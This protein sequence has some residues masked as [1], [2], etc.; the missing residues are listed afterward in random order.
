MCIQHICSLQNGCIDV[1]GWNEQRRGEVGEEAAV[2]ALQLS[3]TPKS[4][5]IPEP[6]PPLSLILR[7]N[8]LALSRL[9]CLAWTSSRFH[10]NIW[11]SKVMMPKKSS[12]ARSFRMRTNAS[13]VWT[14]GG[15]VGYLIQEKPWIDAN[16]WKTAR[17]AA[18]NERPTCWIFLPCM[19]PLWSMMKTTFLGMRGRLDGAK[20][21][22]KNLDDLWVEAPEKVERALGRIYVFDVWAGKELSS[23]PWCLRETSPF[24]HRTQWPGLRSCRCHHS[25][26]MISAGPLLGRNTATPETHIGK[27][28]GRIGETLILHGCISYLFLCCSWGDG[29]SQVSGV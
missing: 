3:K 5:N 26:H 1:G 7:A 10:W 17:K 28:G 8:V 11:L 13:R 14:G 22:T 29:C 9:A 16:D 6:S 12:S 21:W 18:A 27:N 23:A 2:D 15:C 19:E 20:W 25:C 24:W 4:G